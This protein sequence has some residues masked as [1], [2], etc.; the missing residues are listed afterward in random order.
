MFDIIVDNTIINSSK[1]RIMYVALSHILK[2]YSTYELWYV[3]VLSF[4]KRIRATY[5]YAN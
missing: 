5:N 2:G 1:N 3:Y 4:F